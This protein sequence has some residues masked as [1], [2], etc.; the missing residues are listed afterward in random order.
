MISPTR[1]LRGAQVVVTGGS[2]GI[3]EACARA[4]TL[5]GS[6]VTIIAADRQ[7][8]IAAADGMGVQLRQ[9]D[10]SDPEQTQG[11]AQWLVEDLDPDVVVHAA[12]IGMFNSAAGFDPAATRRLLEINLLAPMTISS[13]VLPAMLRRGRGHLVF[14]GSIAGALGVAGESV[15]SASKAGLATYASS[16]RLEVAGRGIGVT[17]VIPG[18]VD[19]NFFPRRGAPY[20]R[21]FPRPVPADHVAAVVIDGVRAN[22][23]EV[24]IPRWLRVPMAVRSVAPQC[25]ASL[26][27]RWG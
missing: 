27:A 8:L 12:G 26:A 24:V 4:F 16:L 13:A 1:S 10:L 25:Y 7:R 15:Y 21:R 18:V 22:R 9:A 19:T 6:R 14:V 20:R 3:G 23:A 2:S 5:A 11:L 17:T